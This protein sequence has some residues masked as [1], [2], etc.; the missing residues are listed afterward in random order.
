MFAVMD[1]RDV[2]CEPQDHRT[3]RPQHRGNLMTSVAA[4]LPTS[5]HWLTQELLSNSHLSSETVYGETDE[6][7]HKLKPTGR[8]DTRA[9]TT[10][11]GALFEPA[12][13]VR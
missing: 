12:L 3:R 10:V 4:A 8:E 1:N 11:H 2:G 5:R 9:T 6:W 7:R 13:L